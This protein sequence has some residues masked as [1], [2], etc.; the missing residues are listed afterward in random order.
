MY[1]VIWY[2]SLHI[3]QTMHYLIKDTRSRCRSSLIVLLFWQFMRGTH[4]EQMPVIN[5]VLE[6]HISHIGPSSA[7]YVRLASCVCS[8]VNME[9]KQNCWITFSY[10]TGYSI[11]ATVG[12]RNYC[13]WAESWY[14]LQ[15]IIS[16]T[17]YGYHFKCNN[18]YQSALPNTDVWV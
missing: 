11:L 4:I 16:C 9:V 10:C 3:S 18:L 8:V 15:Y 1:L 6:Q 2:L 14:N 17:V 5:I 13:R 12:S 7:M